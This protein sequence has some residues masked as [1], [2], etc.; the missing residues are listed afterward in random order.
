MAAGPPSCPSLPS[1]LEPDPDL[2]SLLDG[3]VGRAPEEETSGDFSDRH[4][5]TERCGDA[6]N[7]VFH[8][9]DARALWEG[10]AG[11]GSAEGSNP[12]SE[13]VIEFRVH[14]G[15]AAH[16]AGF[17]QGDVFELKRR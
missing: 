7:T 12:L 11:R 10:H 17:I 13:L 14:P 16:L 2:L 3:F 1:S 15:T 5:H 6:E 8:G 4:R 9:G